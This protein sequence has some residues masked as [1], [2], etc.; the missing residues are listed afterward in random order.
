[1]PGSS[2]LEEEDFL[3]TSSDVTELFSIKKNST[4]QKGLDLLSMPAAARDYESPVQVTM[5]PLFL[6]SSSL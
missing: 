3:P 6:P 1:M 4:F 5:T 2:K